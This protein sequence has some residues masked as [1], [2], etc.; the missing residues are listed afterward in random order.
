[1]SA[2]G[3][4]LDEDAC[5]R[6]KDDTSFYVGESWDECSNV[7]ETGDLFT[8]YEADPAALETVTTEFLDHLKTAM[9]SK[10]E[11]RLSPEHLIVQLRPTKE[12]AGEL[13]SQPFAGDLS[14][15]LMSR[16]NGVIR[17]V[18]QSELTETGLAPD[19]AIAQAKLNAQK[20][21]AQLMTEQIRRVTYAAAQDGLI[22]QTLLIDERCNPQSEAEAILVFER[23]GMLSV[24]MKDA[25][26]VSNLIGMARMMI[27]AEE[28]MSRTII[29]CDAGE[30]SQFWPTPKSN[31]SF[32]ELN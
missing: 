1:M 12:I 20:R 26:G 28:T 21:P 15:L 14:I 13:V 17:P 22:T 2:F 32:S 30:W 11:A 5:L 18:S 9:A 24:Q 19:Q 3:R 25:V 23:N 10:S 16:M 29:R 4:M 7:V 27:N 31:V 8:V 6:P